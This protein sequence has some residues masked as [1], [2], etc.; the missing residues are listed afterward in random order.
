MEKKIEKV[1]QFYTALAQGDFETVGH[2]SPMS[3]YGI[4]RERVHCRAFTTASRM[5][6][7]IWEEWLN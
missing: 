2:C 1:R 3:W 4:S 5:F 6:S 7:P